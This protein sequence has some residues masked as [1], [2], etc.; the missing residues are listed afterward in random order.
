MIS[1]LDY[2]GLKKIVLWTVIGLIYSNISVL[3]SISFIQSYW[4]FL[5]VKLMYHIL[6]CYKDWNIVLKA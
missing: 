4:L 1:L 2:L 6:I 5:F 3:I